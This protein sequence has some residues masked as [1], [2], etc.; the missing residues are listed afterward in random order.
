MKT[1]SLQGIHLSASERRRL[2]FQ[3]LL[4]ATPNPDLAASVDASIERDRQAV[5]QATQDD[6]Y[7]YRLESQTRGTPFLGDLFGN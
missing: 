4:K 3:R 2:E 7:R 1:F 6:P 5:E